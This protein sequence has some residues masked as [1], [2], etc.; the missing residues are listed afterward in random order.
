MHATWIADPILSISFTLLSQ[1]S[2]STLSGAQ[3]FCPSAYSLPS[4]RETKQQAHTKQQVKR[5]Q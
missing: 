4:G 3:I 2:H 1:Q 5:M